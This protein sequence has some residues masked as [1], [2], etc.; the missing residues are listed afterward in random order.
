ML[1]PPNRVNG[2]PRNSGHRDPLLVRPIP[3]RRSSMPVVQP[4]P[5]GFVRSPRRHSHI[6]DEKFDPENPYSPPDSP[7][8]GSSTPPGFRTPPFSSPKH[9]GYYPTPVQQSGEA[10]IDEI[11]EEKFHELMRAFVDDADYAKKTADLAEFLATQTSKFLSNLLNPQTGQVTVSRTSPYDVERSRRYLHKR[12]LFMFEHRHLSPNEAAQMMNTCDQLIK[13]I[14]NIPDSKLNQWMA[15]RFSCF[16]GPE[17]NTNYF[18]RIQEI[19][20]RIKDAVTHYY[21]PVRKEDELSHQ[22]A[23]R[24]FAIKTLYFMMSALISFDHG[25]SGKVM[26]DVIDNFRGRHIDPHEYK[27]IHYVFIGLMWGLFAFLYYCAAHNFSNILKNLPEGKLQ[28]I[29][30]VVQLALGTEMAYLLTL[31]GSLTRLTSFN[32]NVIPF[33]ASLGVDLK[34]RRFDALVLFRFIFSYISVLSLGIETHSSPGAAAKLIWNKHTL[35]PTSCACQSLKLA[36]L[37]F[38]TSISIIS[39]IVSTKDWLA[40]EEKSMPYVGKLNTNLKVSLISIISVVM[41]SSLFLM[42]MR[43]ISFNGFTRFMDEVQLTRAKH[44]E[45]GCCRTTMNTLENYYHSYVKGNPRRSGWKGW[46]TFFIKTSTFLL[47]GL[48][49]SSYN[50]QTLK[51]LR[52]PYAELTYEWEVIK[53]LIIFFSFFASAWPFVTAADKLLP[54]L[55]GGPR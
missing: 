1:N 37:F 20:T 22:T 23:C 41:N 35:N 38:L 45:R 30:Y 51:S 24:K 12:I 2:G 9:R 40:D 13:D 54:N 27:R 10:K 55:L 16:R 3:S 4:N 52:G 7:G 25:M 29:W 31:P 50:F 47:S 44:P 32:E 36:L 5:D 11:I 33:F 19:E 6:Q 48:A 42:F 46:L 17:K 49:F 8:S 28:K 26:A 18:K 21:P 43:D 34:G 14:L 39:Y 53:A 15:Q